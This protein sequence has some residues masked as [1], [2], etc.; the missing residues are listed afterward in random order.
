MLDRVGGV[1]RTVTGWSE[2]VG[3]GTW[4]MLQHE[5]TLS[6]SRGWNAANTGVASS[7]SPHWTNVGGMLS[8]LVQSAPG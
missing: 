3:R 5:W 8:D 6:G 2:E 7:P 4:T 1:V